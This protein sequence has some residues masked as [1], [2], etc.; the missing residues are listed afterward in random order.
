MSIPAMPRTHLIISQPYLPF[1]FLNSLFDGPTDAD[2]MNHLCQA[3][4]RR[5]ENNEIGHIRSFCLGWYPSS[6]H[7]PSFPGGHVLTLH[8][9]ATPIV[10]AWPFGPRSEE[11]R[12]GKE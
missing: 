4:L 6:N 12:V 7:H 2:D 11:R 10:E 1:R 8:F 3:R 5:S 9:K